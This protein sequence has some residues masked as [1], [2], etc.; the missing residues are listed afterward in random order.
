[1]PMLKEPLQEHEIIQLL[2]IHYGID[3]EATQLISGGA[4][5]NAL[6]YKADAKFNSYFVKFKYGDHDEINL[7]IIRL[8]HDS[9]I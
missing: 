2:K 8:L 5:M 7:S 1:M 6:A 3:I 9:G 4:D